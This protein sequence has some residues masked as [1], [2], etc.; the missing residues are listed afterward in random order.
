MVCGRRHL[1]QGYEPAVARRPNRP[2]RFLNPSDKLLHRRV[3]IRLSAYLRQAPPRR[4]SQFPSS[5]VFISSCMQS[6]RGDNV[7]LN[8]PRSPPTPPRRAAAVSASPAPQTHFLDLKSSVTSRRVS[9]NWR[10]NPQT[11]PTVVRARFQEWTIVSYNIDHGFCL[12]LFY[13]RV[14]KRSAILACGLG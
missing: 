8:F 14:R 3:L 4:R 7:G 13:F 6:C 11:G 12:P 9:I 2:D 10:K 1:S 5:C